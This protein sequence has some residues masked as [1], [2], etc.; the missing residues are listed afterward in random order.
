MRRF[1]ISLAL[2]LSLFACKEVYE[3]PPKSL[4]QVS[5]LN[6][7]TNKSITSKI[8]VWGEGINSLWIQDLSAN[9][10]MI[11][12]SMNEKSKFIIKFDD[13]IDTL[14]INS[15]IIARYESIETGFY[16]DFKI[17]SIHFSKSRIKQVTITDSLITKN[18]HENIKLYIS[19][20]ST[21]GQ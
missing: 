18:W 1:I 21:S 5:L 6:S 13:S 10:F 15:S 2:L 9:T 12:L 3:I 16:N 11:P 14:T 7:V 17:K 20:L 8:T 19:P 4:V